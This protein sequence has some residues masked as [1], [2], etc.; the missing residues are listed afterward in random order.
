MAG[1]G[2]AFLVVLALVA[3]LRPRPE[4][5]EP[6][7]EEPGAAEPGPAGAPASASASAKFEAAAP[8]PA[9]RPSSGSRV[10]AVARADAAF[11]AG[12]WGAARDLYLEIL[13]AGDALEAA[14]GDRV[15]RWAHGRLALAL[16]RAARVPGAPLISEPP[17]DYREA[18]R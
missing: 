3:I 17:L 11:D 16:A 2:V 14:E 12:D 9:S 7:V 13:L 15:L 18:P 1:C 5:A 10:A 4:A 6:L 8:G